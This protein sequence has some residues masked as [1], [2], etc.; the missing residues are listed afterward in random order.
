[1]TDKHL[2]GGVNAAFIGVTDRQPHLD[3][4]V[5]QLGWLVEDE[6]VLPAEQASALWGP[7]IGEVAFTVLTAAGAQ[8]GRLILLEVPAQEAGPHPWQADTGFIAINMY[9]RDIQVSHTELS[10]AGQTWVTPPATWRVPL[11]EQIV[12]VTQG[13]LR[14][15][16]STDIVFVEPAQARGTAAWDA[17]PDRHYTE[18]T[19]VVCHVPDFEAE[20]GFWGPDGLGLDSWYDV[21]FTDPGLDEMAKLPSGTVMRLAFLAGATTARIEVTRME[22]RE[23]GTDLRAHQRTA[24][25]VG[26]SGW[27]LEV[28]DLDAAVARATELG[29]TVHTGPQDGPKALFGGRPVAFLDTPNGLPVTFV[30]AN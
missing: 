10:A 15:P 27:L 25:H 17:D 16:E 26:H 21:S 14:A 8:H 3:L 18:L 22:N 5:G 2:V 9:T 20:A 24:Q 1:M 12:T 30:Q 7:G 28:R 4:Y 23:I 6:G 13:F 11:G 19:S 29:G